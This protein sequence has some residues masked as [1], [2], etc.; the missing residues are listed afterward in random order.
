MDF[1]Q[2]YGPVWRS[3]GVMLHMYVKSRSIR[4]C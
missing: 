2:L 4:E 3:W 1:R